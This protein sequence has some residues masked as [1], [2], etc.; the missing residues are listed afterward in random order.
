MQVGGLISQLT[1]FIIMVIRIYLLVS[2]GVDW[3]KPGGL[4]II[5]VDWS[6]SG[7]LSL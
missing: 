5:G 2:I 6:K 7:G 1:S 3:S 4:F